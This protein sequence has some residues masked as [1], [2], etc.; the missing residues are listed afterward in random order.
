MSSQRQQIQL[1]NSLHPVAWMGPYNTSKIQSISESNLSCSPRLSQHHLGASRIRKTHAVR[2]REMNTHFHC[3]CSFEL[4][5][6][7]EQHQGDHGHNLFEPGG[8]LVE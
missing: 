5:W 8:H 6:Y 7:V 3:H 2:G 1:F 4:N